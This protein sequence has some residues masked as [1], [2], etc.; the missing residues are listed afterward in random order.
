MTDRQTT[1]HLSQSLAE[2]KIDFLIYLYRQIVILS[3][4]Q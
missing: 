1:R 3:R 2:V 4:V